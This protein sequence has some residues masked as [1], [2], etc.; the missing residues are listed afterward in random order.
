MTN[1][2]QIFSRVSSGIII[3]YTTLFA[4][5]FLVVNYRNMPTHTLM[6]VLPIDFIK[7]RCIFT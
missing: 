7:R 2:P 1:I 6:H 3:I 4:P 5:N